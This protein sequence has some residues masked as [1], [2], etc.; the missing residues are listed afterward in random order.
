MVRLEVLVLFFGS[1]LWGRDGV[2][3]LDFEDP[4]RMA[5]LGGIVHGY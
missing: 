4:G 1:D 5:S 2:G 3:R